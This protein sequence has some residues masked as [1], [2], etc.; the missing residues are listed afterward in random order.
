M[1]VHD[2][3][4]GSPEWHQHRA[5]HFNASD[6]PAMMGVSPYKT[7][8]DLLR[9]IATGVTPEVDAGTQMR[10]NEGHRAE[11]LARPL[12]EQIIGQELYPITGSLWKYSASFDGL[13]I[14]EEIAFEHKS[15]NDDIRA[16]ADAKELPSLYRVQMEQQLMISG[17]EKCLFLATRWNGDELAE[18]VELWYLPD[19]ELRQKIVMGWEQFQA[20]LEAYTPPTDGPTT[21]AAPVKDLPA[22]A[23]TVNGQITLTD[24]LAVFGECLSTFI[25][26]IDKQ[27]DD[28]QG[29]ADA[30]AAI[31][32]LVKAQAALEQAETSA[33]AQTATIDEMRRT[34]ALYKE[35][36]RTTR[37]TLEKMVKTRKDAIRADIVAKGK[38]I[39]CSHITDLNKRLGKPYMPVIPENFAA[40]IKGM[41]TLASLRN[42]VDTE[43]A[44]VKIEA[45]AVADR[46]QINIDKLREL[47]TDYMFL[48]ADAGKIVLKAND[49]F[50]ILVNSRIANHRIAEAK[51]EEEQRE[52]IRREEAE[53]LAREQAKTAAPQVA[54]P[55]TAGGDL[56]HTTPVIAAATPIEQGTAKLRGLIAQEMLGM[57]AGELQQVLD[58]CREIR[59]ARKERAMA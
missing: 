57:S 3:I 22:L 18:K 47:A 35:Q 21:V 59:A 14:G 29:F 52:R 46:I 41:K 15:L 13:T 10:F 43:L 1:I 8:S 55:A 5:T 25:E 32:V 30:E 16:C 20:D 26:G 34:V 33:L 42:A 36:A 39:L 28:D 9:E 24:N 51:K 44:R 54:S 11:A 56:P 6:A 48:F 4:Q 53:R 17:A 38:A 23:I 7:R 49:D 31:K 45:N 40:V 58:A 27:P 19:M 12:A 2:L 50:T 37:L